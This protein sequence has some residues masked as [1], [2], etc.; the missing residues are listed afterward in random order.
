[1]RGLLLCCL[2]ACPAGAE[3]ADYGEVTLTGL[4]R[5][6]W[7]Y[8]P[9]GD[10]SAFVCNMNDEGDAMAVRAGPGED[11]EVR[12][13]LLRLATVHVDTT[14]IV[15]DW[16]RVLT[17]YRVVSVDGTTVPERILHVSG[18]AHTDFLCDFIH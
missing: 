14:Q 4:A 3:E 17:A 15:G 6:S 12:R 7:P 10:V 11:H 8:N 16:V 13:S 9:P 18:W 2:L 1:M 5:E